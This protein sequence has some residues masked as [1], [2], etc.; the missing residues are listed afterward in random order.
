MLRDVSGSRGYRAPPVSQR[1]WR[2]HL[3]RRRRRRA[4]GAVLPDASG[5]GDSA[6][7]PEGSAALRAAGHWELAVG[8]PRC[9]VGRPWGRAAALA[10]PGNPD[11]PPGAAQTPLRCLAKSP[12]AGPRRGPPPRSGPPRWNTT[13]E[14]TH[15]PEVCCWTAP[16]GCETEAAVAI[17]TACVALP[18]VAVVRQDRPLPTDG[19]DPG[20]GSPRVP[21]GSLRAPQRPQGG[22]QQSATPRA[23]S[24]EDAARVGTSSTRQLW[25]PRSPQRSSVCCAPRHQV[26][27]V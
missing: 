21:P 24:N 27:L 1:R 15:R 6:G 18:A 20:S 26:V 2:E 19:P 25:G 23:R 22:R 8:W 4:G 9:P 11:G 7:V 10:A 14:A 12:P 17:G 5:A 16:T 3:F 13:P